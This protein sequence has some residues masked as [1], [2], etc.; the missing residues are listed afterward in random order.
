ME[1]LLIG[2]A[3][4][5]WGTLIVSLAAAA[6]VWLI[7]PEIAEIAAPSISSWLA[8]EFM[9]AVAALLVTAAAFR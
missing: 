9:I 6:A 3:A 1:K 8:A 4:F 5:L 2:I 7:T